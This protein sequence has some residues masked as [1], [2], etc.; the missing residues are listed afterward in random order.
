MDDT[1]LHTH[2]PSPPA[3][4]TVLTHPGDG[5]GSKSSPCSGDAAQS[6]A[7]VPL[8]GGEALE[9]GS[10]DCSKELREG[11]KNNLETETSV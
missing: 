9:P 10:Q 6:W 1:P 5:W 11:K 7:A 3:P 4:R 2:T 8:D